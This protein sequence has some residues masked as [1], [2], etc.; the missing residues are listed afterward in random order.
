MSDAPEEM[1]PE[2]RSVDV[3]RVA[4]KDSSAKHWLLTVHDRDEWDWF[5]NVSNYCDHWSFQEE[6][7][8]L[9]G[10]HHIQAYLC[11]KGQTRFSAVKRHFPT[12]HVEMVKSATAA[13]EYCLKSDT[14]VDGGLTGRSADAPPARG[15][16]ASGDPKAPASGKRRGPSERELLVDFVDA[17]ASWADT[18]RTFRILTAKEPSFV[19]AIFEQRLELEFAERL[20]G[21]GFK[22]QV[23]IFFGPPGTGKSTS[24]KLLFGGR[25][26]FRMGAGRWADGYEYERCLMIDDMEPRLLPRNQ[27][28]Q[29]LENGACRWEVKG[30]T[31]MLMADIIM[32]TSNYHP[33]V[34]FSKL[35]DKDE[36]QKE[37]AAVRAVA[38]LRRAEVFECSS[39]AEP[40]LL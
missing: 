18:K 17:G 14:R 32:I 23:G 10:R 3:G 35:D 37:E 9:T 40:K 26:F 27:L 34:W 38:I 8:P 5:A 39:T 6:M 33:N 21:G 16:P 20:R 12:A 13:F 29:L 15:F 2:A 30:S 31:T 22:P 11:F 24:A 36:K 25:P 4:K 7:C 1:H 28:L 19:R